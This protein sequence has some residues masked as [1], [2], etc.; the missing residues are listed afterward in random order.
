MLDFTKSAKRF[1]AVNLIDNQCIRVRMPTKRVFD[2]LMGLKD[3][4][5]TLTTDDAGQLDEIYD[6]IAV[7]MS[8]NLEHKEITSSYLSDLFDIEDVQIFF[9]AYM[10][11][12]G[13][14]VSS[15]NSKSPPSPTQVQNSITGA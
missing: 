8:N 4:L 14:V 13:V 5:T 10:A 9:E 2:A 11:F 15:P 6:L 3:R 12:L 7:V 1:L